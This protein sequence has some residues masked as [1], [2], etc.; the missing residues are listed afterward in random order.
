MVFSPQQ[1]FQSSRADAYGAVA[2]EWLEHIK[3]TSVEM[4]STLILWSRYNNHCEKCEQKCFKMIMSVTYGPF[5]SSLSMI[6]PQNSRLKEP[7]LLSQV[8]YQTL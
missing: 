6:S 7:I 3:G 4:D 5:R 8:D 1:I 2:F